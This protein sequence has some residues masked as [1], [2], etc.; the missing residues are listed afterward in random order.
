MT[1][2]LL[3]E[4]Q[5]K[6]R[7]NLSQVFEK[8]GY[9]VETCGTGEQGFYMATTEPF[10]A[11]ILDLSL[12]GR[13]GFQILSDLR[14]GGITLPVLILT[15]R[16]SVDDRV[17]GLDLG[18]DDYLVK[19]FAHLELL[20]RVRAL[21]RRSR[22]NQ[23]AELKC[24]DVHI[25]VM[26]RRVSRNGVEIE[27]SVREYE[28]LEYLM[29]HKNSNVT[30]QMLSIDIWKEPGGIMTNAIDVC[31][32]SLRKKIE[33]PGTSPLILTIR[34]VGYTIRETA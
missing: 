9:E 26:A 27:L 2:L 20:A 28:L 34:G 8:D 3:I 22:P 24:N 7:R 12:P 30:R 17:R 19:P 10:D 16:D 29:R 14:A 11:L 23:S 21:L 31:V 33:L 15:A 1:R 13:D 18:A 32:N 25:D 4:D 6:L 5:L